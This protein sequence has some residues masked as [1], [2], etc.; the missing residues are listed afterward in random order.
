MCQSCFSRNAAIFRRQ[1]ALAQEGAA[2]FGG[3]AGIELLQIFRQPRIRPRDEFLQLADVE[4]LV[5][6]INRRKLAP[7]NRQQLPAEELQLAAQQR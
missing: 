5:P 4:V 7:V 2:R 3:I 6:R 1:F